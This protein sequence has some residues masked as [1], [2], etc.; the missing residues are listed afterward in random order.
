MIGV[1][2]IVTHIATT[3]ISVGTFTFMMS[4][5]YVPAF[6]LCLFLDKKGRLEISKIRISNSW[7]TILGV[8]LVELG[9]IPYNIAFSLGEAALVSGV[10]SG[11]IVIT[12]VLASVFL[13]ERIDRYQ[14]V[15]IGL[16]LLGVVFLGL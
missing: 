7:M 2:E 9:L 4:V 8:G 1:A 16:V 15:G 3:N 10:S 6:L 11:R 12:A 13:K 14:V 5:S